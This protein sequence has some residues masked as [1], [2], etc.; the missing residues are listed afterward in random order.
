MFFPRLRRRAKWVF[1][2]LALAFAIGF[3]GFGVGAGGSGIGDY[4]S[5][6]FHRQPGSDTPSLDDARERVREN[7][8]DADAQRDLA[9]AL[10]AEQRTD[11][12]LAAWEAYTRLRPRDVE[13]LESLAVL[14]G[15]KAREADERMAA[16][17]TQA[18]SAFFANEIHDPS[19][20]LGEKLGS[21]R[22]TDF[23]RQELEQAFTQARTASVDLHGKEADVWERLTKLQPDDPT[24]WADLGRS[25]IAAQ[26]Y[27]RALRAY[28]RYLQLAPDAVDAPQVRQVVRQLRLFEKQGSASGTP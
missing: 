28:R 8:G 18:S 22:I 11:E 6:L 20:K 27:P 9:N 17:Q 5:D 13:G 25:A 2:F 15:T 26:D 19:S 10:Q 4:V 16:I 21:D 24:P 12:A 7:P 1:A 23:V 3:V 14:Y